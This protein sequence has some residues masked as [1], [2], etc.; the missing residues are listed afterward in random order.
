MSKKINLY[1]ETS[2]GI[3]SIPFIGIKEVDLFT[4]EYNNRIEFLNSLI[5]I[6]D[7]SIDIDDVGVMYLSYKDSE[8]NEFDYETCLPVKYGKDNYNVDS[9]I[10][11]FSLYLR[12]DQSRLTILGIRNVGD[13]IIYNFNPGYVSD[14]DVNLIARTY[15]D[16]DY[17]KIRDTYFRL[18]DDYSIKI[19]KVST[20]SADYSRL[21]LSQLESREDNFIQYLIE[22]ASRGEEQAEIARDELAK[23]DHEEVRKNIDKTY[24]GVIDGLSDSQIVNSMDI[25]NLEECTGISIN[26]LREM[27]KKQINNGRGR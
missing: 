1:I 25:A 19:D 22:L 3:V 26:K 12:E 8:E 24:Y 10:E 9:V 18:C 13:K 17:R 20:R 2:K 23:L 16:G 27:C 6:L 5:N 15:L 4:V 7:L 21:E 14:N 11:N